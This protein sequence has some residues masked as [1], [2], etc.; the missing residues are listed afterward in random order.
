[1]VGQF[2]SSFISAKQ[3]V[4][5]TISIHG[6]VRA[7]ASR[8]R[9]IICHR[10]CRRPALPSR[11]SLYKTCSQNH[12][13]RPHFTGWGSAAAAS[14]AS[15]ENWHPLPY[16]SHGAAFGSARTKVIDAPS[17]TTEAHPRFTPLAN[18]TQDPLSEDHGG[19]TDGWLCAALI[20][21]QYCGT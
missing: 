14:E 9:R 18:A 5:H 4:V 16:S 7:S 11:G 3:L 15:K 6:R 8:T 2:D 12:A 10:N 19:T 1:M 13:S 17:L 21:S 20:R